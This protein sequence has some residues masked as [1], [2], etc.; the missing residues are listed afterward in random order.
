MMH[1]VEL[2]GVEG[3]YDRLSES[4]IE[5]TTQGHDFVRSPVSRSA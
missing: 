4:Q 3:C 5:A 1:S 2:S